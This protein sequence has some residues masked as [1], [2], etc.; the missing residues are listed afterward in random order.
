M[1]DR[2]SVAQIEINVYTTHYRKFFHGLAF[3]FT[4]FKTATGV[5]SE[6]NNIKLAFLSIKFVFLAI[7][8]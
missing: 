8:L 6:K 3:L 1:S 7:F 2:S 5:F 4:S